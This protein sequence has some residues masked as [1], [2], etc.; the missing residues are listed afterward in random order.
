[1]TPNPTGI[2]LGGINDDSPYHHPAHPGR[3]GHADSFAFVTIVLR[4]LGSLKLAPE[5]AY[6]RNIAVT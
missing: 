3:H 1:L 6:H 5:L 4:S 2:R